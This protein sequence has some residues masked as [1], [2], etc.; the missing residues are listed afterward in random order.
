MEWKRLQARWIDRR[1]PVTRSGSRRDRGRMPV[2]RCEGERAVSLTRCPHP[3]GQEVLARGGARGP[4]P[5]T[6]CSRTE[7]YAGGGG[8][9]SAACRGRVLVSGVGK[10]GIVAQRIAASFR[11]TGTPAFFLHPV[12]AMHGDLGSG[13]SGRRRASPEPR[14]ERARSCSAFFRSSSAS[15]FRS[16]R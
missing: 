5:A 15:P 1:D 8:A 6:P 13:R 7:A 14:A 4:L 16:W 12:E 9:A 10:S 11:S 3:A 2:R